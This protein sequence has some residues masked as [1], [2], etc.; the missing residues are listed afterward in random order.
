MSSKNQSL[1]LLRNS[2]LFGKVLKIF[3]EAKKKFKN[4]RTFESNI[5]INIYF[6]FSLIFTI[7]ILET[8]FFK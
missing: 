6:L 1:E 5:V 4:G 3:E 7:D 8:N 2:L